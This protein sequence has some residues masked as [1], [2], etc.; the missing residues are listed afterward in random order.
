MGH[1]MPQRPHQAVPNLRE[2]EVAGNT[3]HVNVDQPLLGAS[4]GG[5][6]CLDI[7]LPDAPFTEAYL[8]GFLG[9]IWT[10]PCLAEMAIA[11]VLPFGLGSCL[12]QFLCSNLDISGIQF[13]TRREAFRLL[14]VYFIYWFWIG[15]ILLIELWDITQAEFLQLLAYQD[16]LGDGV[17]AQ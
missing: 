7:S 8:Y 5:Y 13:Y 14:R 1:V 2:S 17:E 10:S 11:I 12:V 15:F 3:S 16:P 6:S 9:E 4:G